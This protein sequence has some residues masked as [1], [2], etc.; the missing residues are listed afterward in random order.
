[1]LLL[2]SLVATATCFNLEAYFAEWRGEFGIFPQSVRD[3]Q[4]PR[5]LQLPNDA[6]VVGPPSDPQLSLVGDFL[7]PVL[8]QTSTGIGVFM[9][10]KLNVPIEG[11]GEQPRA[12]VTFTSGSM[13]IGLGVKRQRATGSMDCIVLPF[14]GDAVDCG[15]SFNF[16]TFTPVAILFRPASGFEIRF[17]G[18]DP[19]LV[20]APG[21]GSFSSIEYV[22]IAGVIP[23]DNLLN[24]DNLAVFAFN[25]EENISSSLESLFTG[26][27]PPTPPTP[28]PPVI[29]M[30]KATPAP[31]SAPFPTPAPNLTVGLTPLPT[32]SPTPRPTPAPT[33]S[34][35]PQPTPSPT[36]DARSACSA[37]GVCAQCVDTSFHPGRA[38]RFCAGA[39]RD[40]SDTCD[41][42]ASGG[43]CP[44][45]AP[46]PAPTPGPTPTEL[47]TTAFS[48]PLSATSSAPTP[49]I[50]TSTVSSGSSEDVSNGAE[51]SPDDSATIIGAVVGAVA[52][53]CLVATIVGVVLFLRKKK[54]AASPPARA[55][56]MAM[57]ARKKKSDYGDLP[58]ASN[59]Y[60]VGV[61]KQVEP[62]NYD[63]GDVHM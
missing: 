43:A 31:K 37:F 2:L 56:E 4:T 17:D 44:T 45:P 53:L 39:C 19:I 36:P 23:N 5:T 18:R 38:C 21:S 63:K 55:G 54:N 29:M 30:P 9:L 13:S 40:M 52:F 26:Y 49:S 20:T 50:S 58:K 25:N 12:L 14:T 16:L 57:K 1:M 60:D 51:S 6:L 32:P 27:K 22:R 62:S 46:T 61:V 15:Q 48:D 59:E 34:P 8:R 35:T 7:I 28:A 42:V 24:I 41:G 11:V 10:V 33:P 47:S 3:E